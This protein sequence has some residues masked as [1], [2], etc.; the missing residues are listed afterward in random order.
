MEISFYE[1]AAIRQDKEF[2]NSIACKPKLAAQGD[3]WCYRAGIRF[4]RY[5]PDS[6]T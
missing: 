4:V 2:F 5:A 1:L 6:G 3:L